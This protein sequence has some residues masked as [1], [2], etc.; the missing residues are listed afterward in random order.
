MTGNGKLSTLPMKQFPLTFKP[1]YS[2]R[3]VGGALGGGGKLKAT[4]KAFSKDGF[5]PLEGTVGIAS[6]SK[7]KADSQNRR[8]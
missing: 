5:L 2:C 1:G 3:K 6:Y 8:G 7:T 4:V